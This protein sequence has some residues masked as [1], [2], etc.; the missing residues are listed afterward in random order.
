MTGQSQEWPEGSGQAK[1][2]DAPVDDA[3]DEAAEKRARR[4]FRKLT[5]EAPAWNFVERAHAPFASHRRGRVRA[6]RPKGRIPALDNFEAFAPPPPSWDWRQHIHINEPFDQHGCNCCTAFAMAATMTDLA[7]IRYGSLRASLSPGHLHW[8]IGRA[9]CDNALDPLAL[10]N[11]ATQQPVALWQPGDYPY[12]PANCPTAHGMGRLGSADYV[13]TPD[14][15]FQALQRGPLLQVMDLYDD[16]WSNYGGGVYRPAAGGK[17][18]GHS[19]EL[20][21]YDINQQFWIVKNSE[22]PGWGEGGFARIGF[23]ECRILTPGGHLALEMT[24]A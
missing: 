7:T 14:Q 6:F 15:A 21:G 10:A 20:V 8:C 19:V 5:R 13:Y 23:G 16:F 3:A 17:F 1:A 4:V 24:L 11:L 2:G 9:V 18:S 22:G 12:N